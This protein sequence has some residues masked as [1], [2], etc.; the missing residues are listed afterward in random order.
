M[1]VLGVQVPKSLQGCHQVRPDDLPCHLKKPRCEAV[2]AG[3]L[4]G[5]FFLTERQLEL[6]SHKN[7]ICFFDMIS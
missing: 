3:A 1:R 4:S 7:S 2:R 6:K 5:G